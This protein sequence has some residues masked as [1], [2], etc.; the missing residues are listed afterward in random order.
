MVENQTREEQ[1]REVL[2]K[3]F[4]QAKRAGQDTVDLM[5]IPVD[6]IETIMEA[7]IMKQKY[8]TQWLDDMNNPL[9]PLKLLSALQSE[10]FKLQYRKE[11]KPKEI[12]ILDYTVIYALKDCLK[13]YSNKEK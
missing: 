8:E 6:S 11:H 3:V 10:I 9:E 12:N 4:V 7:L 2:N 13:R 1:I 5:G